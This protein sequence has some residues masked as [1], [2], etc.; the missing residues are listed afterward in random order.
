MQS[1]LAIANWN[2]TFRI[3]SD[4]CG[5]YI[6]IRFYELMRVLGNLVDTTEVREHYD[7]E[8]VLRYVDYIIYLKG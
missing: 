2:K 5:P 3:E 7:A 1:T 8:G 4:E 6:G